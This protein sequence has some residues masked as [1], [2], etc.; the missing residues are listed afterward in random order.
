TRKLRSRKA[1]INVVGGGVVS[2][3]SRFGGQ[4]TTLQ[5]LT[6]M[7]LCQGMTVVGDG[8]PDD[9]PGHAGVC[10]QHEAGEDD[11][12]LMRARILAR[13]VVDVSRATR[14]LRAR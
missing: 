5:A 7:M 13:R 6:S 12:G 4:E 8:H 14:M 1:L 10:L 3:S 11:Q 2:G 9:D